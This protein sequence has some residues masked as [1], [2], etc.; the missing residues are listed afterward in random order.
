MSTPVKIHA[1]S[2]A[3]PLFREVLASL[4]LSYARAPE[5]GDADVVV[6]DGAA[7]W[8][9]RVS[10]HLDAGVAT[11]LIVDPRPD[12]SAA[13]RDLAQAAEASGARLAVSETAAS[14]PAVHDIAPQLEGLDTITVVSRGPASAS[15]LLFDQLRLLRALGIGQLVERD[16]TR[17]RKSVVVTLDGA[18]GGRALLVKLQASTT[19]AGVLQHRVQAYGAASIV[20]AELYGAD[21]ARPARVECSTADAASTTPTIFESAHR[22][23]WRALHRE[24]STVDLEAFA[25]DIDLLGVHAS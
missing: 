3:E 18:L 20:T 12:D 22:A 7:G 6:A 9:G 15:D 23:S 11:A 2:G 5:V 8:P 1:D 21:T 14:N 10:A 13:V 16:A 19:E 4:P 24:G 17:G 25:D